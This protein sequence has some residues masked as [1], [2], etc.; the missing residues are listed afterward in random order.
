[1]SR[2]RK[3]KIVATL[4]P[5]SSTPQMMAALFDA[6]ADVFRINMSP[7]PHDPLKRMHGDLRALAEAKGGPIG[8]LVDLQAPK[9]RLG[10]LKGGPRQLQEGENIRLVL[11]E[12]S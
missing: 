5:A 4:G 7:T 6:G 11:A 9:I 10:V 1:M 8:I 3:T 2:Q 12:S